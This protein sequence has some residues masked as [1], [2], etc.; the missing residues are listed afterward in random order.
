M[1]APDPRQ[2]VQHKYVVVHGV[3]PDGARTLLGP[4]RMADMGTYLRNVAGLTPVYT[5]DIF[6]VY[7]NEEI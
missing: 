2:R 7:R 3:T 4:D 6:T 5:D 1:S